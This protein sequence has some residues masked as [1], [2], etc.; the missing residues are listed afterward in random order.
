MHEESENLWRERE[1]IAR[2]KFK[3]KQ[4]QELQQRLLEGQIPA[5]NNAP[6]GEAD[7]DD[8]VDLELS[9]ASDN[10]TPGVPPPPNVTSSNVALPPAPPS[11]A[12]IASQPSPAA[13]AA[14]AVAAVLASKASLRAPQPHLLQV[15]PPALLL[16][17]PGPC[18]PIPAPDAALV[19]PA[20][21][22]ASRTERELVEIWDQWRR[23]EDVAVAEENRTACLAYLR[24]GRCR[25]GA[26]C[27]KTHP[28]PPVSPVLLLPG[29]YIPPT[30]PAG[31][32]PPLDPEGAAH[33]AAFFED[34]WPEFTGVGPVVALRVSQNEAPHLRGNVYVQYAAL[35]DAVA[36]RLRFGARFYGGRPLMA[37]FCPV[38]RWPPTNARATLPLEPPPRRPPAAP[39]RTPGRSQQQQNS[40]LVMSDRYQPGPPPG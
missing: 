30:S 38:T 25:F 2:E 12:T 18:P 32:Q 39:A 15:L 13:A 1:R 40:G 6:P 5:A 16:P 31:Q 27:T 3:E 21:G 26:A 14:A 37:E 17:T 36:A 10:D 28:Q 24:T 11:V 33:Y 4:Y 22:L 9:G 29:M 34:V 7:D 20:A 35:R 23:R 19:D 8:D